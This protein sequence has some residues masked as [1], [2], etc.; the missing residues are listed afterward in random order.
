MVEDGAIQQQQAEGGEYHQFGV[1]QSALN[2][3]EC[4]EDPLNGVVGRSW[5][6]DDVFGQEVQ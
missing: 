5:R 2:D 1:G 4:R 3:Q 6:Y